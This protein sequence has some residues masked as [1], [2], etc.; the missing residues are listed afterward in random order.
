ME[1]IRLRHIGYVIIV[2]KII[3]I[4]F[5]LYQLFPKLQADEIH[6]NTRFIWF[7]I[8]GFI[9]QLID[10]ALGMAYGVSCSTL[11][12]NVGVSPKLASAS[13]HT[14]E[15]FTTGVSG[16]SH[17]KMRN[18]DKKLFFRIVIPGVI[19]AMIGAYLISDVFDGKMIKP[20]IACYLLI[21]GMVII[22]KGF[23]NKKKEFVEVKRAGLLAFAGGMLDAIGGGGWGPIVTSNII[24]QGKNPA[25]T[26][27]TVNTAEFFITFFSTG[28]FLFFVGID[29]WDI[30]L[31]LILG[32]VVAAPLGAYLSKKVNKRAMMFI[33]GITVIITSLFTIYKAVYQ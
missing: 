3:L 6:L 7:V 16:L 13:V 9:A 4:S 10:G 25:E 15:V 12:L 20:Y 22:Y 17:I 30:L 14:A 33:V 28:V 8:A 18:I 29:H 2:L 5:L 11:L 23:K 21:L 27:G 24:N 32:G 31:G 26:I 1:R 19:S